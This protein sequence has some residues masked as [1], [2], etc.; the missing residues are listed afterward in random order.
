MFY[1][2]RYYATHAKRLIPEETEL[3]SKVT[4]SHK[5]PNDERL[6]FAK[7]NISISKT[8]RPVSLT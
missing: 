4:Y 1:I 3:I 7:T 2:C 6:A 5:E 8:V